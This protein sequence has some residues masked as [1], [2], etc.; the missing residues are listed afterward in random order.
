MPSTLCF[1]HEFFLIL[2]VSIFSPLLEVL[3]IFVSISFVLCSYSALNERGQ[4][5]ACF[6][7][8]INESTLSGAVQVLTLFLSYH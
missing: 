3:V 2:P 7:P 8:L 4:V 5:H 6:D 1:L